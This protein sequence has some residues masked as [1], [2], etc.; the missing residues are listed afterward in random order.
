MGM[1]DGKK[2][3]TAQIEAMDHFNE[4]FL[5]YKMKL[6]DAHHKDPQLRMNGT[7]YH[8]LI[9]IYQRQSCMVTDISRHLHLSSGATTISLNQLEKDN[10]I[11]RLRSNED[12]RTVMVT[13]TPNGK[14]FIETVLDVRNRLLAEMIEPLSS[15]EQ[16]QLFHIIAKISRQLAKKI[17][18][19]EV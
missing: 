17:A 16:D 3:M 4:T 15:E 9:T 12:R 13:L 8:I 10:L 1:R 6:L 7:K 5:R 2:D 19:H 14:R 11:E 18:S